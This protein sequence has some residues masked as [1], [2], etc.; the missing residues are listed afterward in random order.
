MRSLL[1]LLLLLLSLVRSQ[2]L[3]AVV[4]MVCICREPQTREER[5]SDWRRPS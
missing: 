5:A 3:A 2:A 1:Q 4:C